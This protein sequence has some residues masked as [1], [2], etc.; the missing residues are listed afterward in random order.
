MIASVNN[1]YYQPVTI[2]VDLL[3]TNNTNLYQIY[4]TAG[5]TQY[6]AT[7]KYVDDTHIQLTRMGGFV[8]TMFLGYK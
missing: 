1:Y 6:Y 3:K 7:F 8:S 5:D 2:P 4:F